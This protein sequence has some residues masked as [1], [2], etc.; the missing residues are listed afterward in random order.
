M[1]RTYQEL[2][3]NSKKVDGQR[4]DAAGLFSSLKTPSSIKYSAT[5]NLLQNFN[6][7]LIVN[8]ELEEKVLG[9]KL[10]HQPGPLEVAKCCILGK[11]MIQRQEIDTHTRGK[12]HGFFRQPGKGNFATW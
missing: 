5:S 7:H 6:C 10:E 4:S 1:L 11:V 9:S 3:D 12:V 2:K 8:A